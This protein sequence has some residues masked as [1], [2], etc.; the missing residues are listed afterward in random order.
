MKKVLIS[1]DEFLGLYESAL[2]DDLSGRCYLMSW[3]EAQPAAAQWVSVKD[4]LPLNDSETD[5]VAVVNDDV[6]W[7]R[8]FYYDGDW[9]NE[10]ENYVENVTHWMSIPPLPEVENKEEWVCGGGPITQGLDVDEYYR[11][12]KR[13]KDGT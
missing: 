3:F 7:Q 2:L 5:F 4:R 6:N 11:K 10:D 12:N 9:F 13:V 8:A 1:L